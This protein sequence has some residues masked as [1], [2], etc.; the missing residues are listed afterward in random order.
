M[1]REFWQER[2]EEKR[3]QKELRK[4]QKKIKGGDYLYY[5]ICGIILA[6]IVIVGPFAC[7]MGD[8]GDIDN[9]DWNSTL[10][11]SEEMQQ[12]LSQPIDVSTLI[13]TS[14]INSADE[15]ELNETLVRAGLEN[16]VVPSEKIDENDTFTLNDE[17]VLKP[18]LAGV[19][20]NAFLKEG[21]YGDSVEVIEIIIYK[22]NSYTMLRTLMKVDLSQIVMGDNL[23]YVYCTTVSRIT[24][25]DGR[26]TS[27][28]EQVNIN[29][30]DED[31]NE[32]LLTTLNSLSLVGV[33]S[34]TN[35]LVVSQ[36]NMFA[37]I[38][39]SRIDVSNVNIRF[40]VD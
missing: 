8:V 6:I 9:Y 15:V 36:I 25:I 31:F 14:A 28:G 3:R 5:K 7:T 20:V 16:F 39:Q 29:D 1:I 24:T 30:Y 19:L 4:S 27:I 23:P 10:G 17:L 11:I 18:N 32:E 22:D 13:T 40:S 21:V 37:T 2:R 38:T 12:R 34:Y 26:L 33:S 35:E